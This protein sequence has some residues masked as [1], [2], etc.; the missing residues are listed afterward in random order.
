MTNQNLS[1]ILDGLTVISALIGLFLIVC[2]ILEF[3][4]VG[5]LNYYYLK[6]SNLFKIKRCR[7]NNHKLGC[8]R[9]ISKNPTEEWSEPRA[10]QRVRGMVAKFKC[11][12]C[13]TIFLK[14]NMWDYKWVDENNSFN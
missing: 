11:D 10:G 4:N 12:R 8:W 14:S 5:G 9:L 13:N 6:L 3:A 2:L 7:A 1:Y